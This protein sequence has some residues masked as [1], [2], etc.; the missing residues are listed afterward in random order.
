MDQLEVARYF[1][2]KPFFLSP[3]VAVILL[4]TSYAIDLI[5]YHFCVI[6]NAS[7]RRHRHLMAVAVERLE[8]SVAALSGL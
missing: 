1:T 2:C 8:L 4:V 6:R 7:P 3:R 5:S